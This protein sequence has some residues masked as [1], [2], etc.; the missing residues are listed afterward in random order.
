MLFP[1]LHFVYLNDFKRIQPTEDPTFLT[2]GGISN[3]LFV[4]ANGIGNWSLNSGYK[5]ACLL[6][7]ANALWRGMKP[8]VPLAMGK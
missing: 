6:L 1:S 8:S 3:I 7:H 4:V 5:A 2:Y